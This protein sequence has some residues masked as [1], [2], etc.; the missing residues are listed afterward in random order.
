MIRGI[1]VTGPEAALPQSSTRIAVLIP[2][3]NEELTIADVVAEFRV[4]LPTADIYVCD[5]NSSDRSVLEATDAGA[6]V[7]REPRLGK[8]YVLQSMLGTVDADIYVI[9][10]GDRTYSADAVQS[11][12]QPILRGE[13]DMVV[14]SRLH[15][16]A[17]AGFT[18]LHWCGN[19]FFVLLLWMLFGISSSDLLSGYRALGRA[20]VRDLHLRSRGFEVETEMTIKAIRSGFRVTHIPVSLARRPHG[21]HSK[22]RMRR[23]GFAIVAKMLALRW[24]LR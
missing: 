21:S 9:V 1:R 19:R 24:R 20:V 14:G 3:L 6:S 7:L 4:A 16:N 23:D 2:C 15:R 12:I 11:L 18:T 10:D 5:N 8:G 22:I 17:A 13:A